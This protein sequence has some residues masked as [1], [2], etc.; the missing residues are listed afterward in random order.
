MNLIKTSKG[1]SVSKEKKI[2]GTSASPVVQAAMEAQ[3][4]FQYFIL[5]TEAIYVQE[6]LI[7]V[8]IR[9]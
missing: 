7:S 4:L 8:V 3:C 9:E 5:I 6:E 2:E 1:E